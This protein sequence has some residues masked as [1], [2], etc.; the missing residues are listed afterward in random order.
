MDELWLFR[1]GSADIY[2]IKNSDLYQL[3]SKIAKE[4][5]DSY[6]GQELLGDSHTAGCY[7]R[8]WQYCEEVGATDMFDLAKLKER[9]REQVLNS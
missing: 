7:I 9:L 8:L 5:F 2:R 4:A 3:G 1:R 6:F